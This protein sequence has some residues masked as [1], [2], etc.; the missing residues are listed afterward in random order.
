[1][2]SIG[3]SLLLSPRLRERGWVWG[4][5]GAGRK[6]E[7][8]GEPPLTPT[9]SPLWGRGEGPLVKLPDSKDFCPGLM[10]ISDRRVAVVHA[11]DYPFVPALRN[12]RG[13]LSVV[14]V[15]S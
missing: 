11:R 9:L 5:G 1:M 13:L 3:R 7:T 15:L 2:L 10:L 6:A 4:R 12:G 8:R 14:L